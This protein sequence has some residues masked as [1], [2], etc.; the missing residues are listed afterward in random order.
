M[1]SPNDNK[2]IKLITCTLFLLLILNQKTECQKS[3]LD[4]TFTFREGLVRTGTALDIITRNTGYNFTYDSRLID[5]EKKASLTF[6]NTKLSVIL[7]SL[8]KND[9]LVFSVIDKYI[10]ISHAEHRHVLLPDT[11]TSNKIKY[12]TGKIIDDET[13]EPL[14]YATIV[15]KKRERDGYEY[16]WRLRDED[17][18]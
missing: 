2:C 9:S 8:L 10:I 3:I 5:Q 14:P 4:S 7:D 12:I 1:S 16:E 15:L 13:L 11:T 6:N 18:A 17:N